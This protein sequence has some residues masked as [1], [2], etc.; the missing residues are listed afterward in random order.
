MIDPSWSV[1]DLDPRTWRAI[2]A[3]FEPSQYIRAAQ[4]GEHGLFVLHDGGR[5]LRV[6]DT[7][8]GPRRD[9]SLAHVDD[10]ESLAAALLEKGEWER[11]HIIDKQHLA[12]VAREA[13]A[14]PRRDLTLDQYYRLVNSLIWDEAGSY[15]T[16]PPRDGSWHG[17]TYEDVQGLVNALPDP[18]SVALVVV[19][20]DVTHIGLV[21]DLRGGRVVTVTTLETFGFP[22]PFF[23]LKGYGFE[24]LWSMLGSR[25]ETRQAP[26]PAAAL[27][28]VRSLF[29]VLIAEPTRERKWALLQQAI[30]REEAFMRLSYGK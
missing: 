26:P 9:L 19:D 28:C 6:V 24:K 12:N 8:A 18:C 16:A 27:L 3:F 7:A 1:L 10:P 2:G 30:E 14:S 21:L 5:V 17:W 25:A 22:A 29:D 20:G 13:Q 11:V 15:V 4:P 23:D